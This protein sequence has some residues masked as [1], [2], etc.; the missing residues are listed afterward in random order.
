MP[1][2]R[3]RKAI[4]LS[5]PLDVHEAIKALA[6]REMIGTSTYVRRLVLQH[7]ERTRSASASSDHHPA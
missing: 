7:V 2:T 4:L 1:E 6:D 3:P 5:L